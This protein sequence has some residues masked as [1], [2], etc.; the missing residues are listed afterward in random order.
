[1]TSSAPQTLAI[2]GERISGDVVRQQNGNG[3]WGTPGPARGRTALTPHTSVRA[4][5]FRAL[6]C[7]AAVMAAIAIAN[8]VKSSLGP[9]GLDKMLVDDIGV[10]ARRRR[11]ATR[12]GRG[13]RPAAVAVA[14]AP[15]TGRGDGGREAA[16]RT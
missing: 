15:R 9:V 1:M 10:R 2:G 3:P 16:C 5:A 7:G 12:R 14:N 8:I 11:D 4:G 13:R 6:L